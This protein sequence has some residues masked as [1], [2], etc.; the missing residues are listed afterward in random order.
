MNEYII[1][2]LKRPN[3][4]TSAQ[5]PSSAK[6]LMH[7]IFSSLDVNGAATDASAY[8]H[9]NILLFNFNFF[10]NFLESDNQMRN[11]ILPS[12]VN[13]QCEQPALREF[14]F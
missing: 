6:C 13:N 10:F 7:D 5:R 14:F 2:Y 3:D 12:T 1:M 8:G 4:V 11:N 9:V